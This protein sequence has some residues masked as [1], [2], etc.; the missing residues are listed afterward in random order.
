VAI[1][2]SLKWC[3]NRWLKVLLLQLVQRKLIRTC[4]RSLLISKLPK[5]RCKSNHR[6]TRLEQ[7]WSLQRRHKRHQVAIKE[8]TRNFLTNL[9]IRKRWGMTMPLIGESVSFTMWKRIATWMSKCRL[10]TIKVTCFS[11]NWRSRRSQSANTLPE[12][13]RR[14]VKL[15]VLLVLTN[16]ILQVKSS[17]MLIHLLT[18]WDTE[19]IMDYTCRWLS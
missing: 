3:G 12:E 4:I 10:K 9:A 1:V 7:V 14:R 17:A 11:V 19:I 15:S 13:R 8:R 16:L 5:P 2:L 18:I 6:Q